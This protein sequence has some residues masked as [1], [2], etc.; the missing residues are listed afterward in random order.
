MTSFILAAFLQL[1][2]GG[3][4]PL[5]QA[6][7]LARRDEATLQGEQLSNL[8]DQQG[9]A[10]G[11]A[12]V[13]CGVTDVDDASGLRVVMRLDAQGRVTKTWLNKQSVLGRCFEKE[14]QSAVFSTDGR[15][16]FYTFIG[17]SF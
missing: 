10:L 12:L 2:S 16:E 6:E 3:D 14:L 7:S 13:N 17:F 15:P 8:S 9:V 4:I 1:T 11:R 5:E